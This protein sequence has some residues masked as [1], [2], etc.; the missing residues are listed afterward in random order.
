M[1]EN[2]SGLKNPSEDQ[3]EYD[4]EIKSNELDAKQ[5]NTK[6]RNIL[7][8]SVGAIS[9][10]LIIVAIGSAV[11]TLL[12]GSVTTQEVAVLTIMT[13]APIILALAL[14]RYVFDGKKS[15]APQPTLMLNVGKELANV[16]VE[17]FKK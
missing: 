11:C 15:D 7:F 9:L 8:Y 12:A 4:S 3:I 6:Q 1:A 2:E 5:K 14:M 10:I 16:L 17:I 13:T